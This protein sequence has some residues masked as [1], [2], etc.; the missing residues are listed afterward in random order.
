MVGFENVVLCVCSVEYVT[1]SPDGFRYRSQMFPTVNG[2][3]RWF[4]DHFQEP[5]PG[6]TPSSS[7]RTR[8]PASVNATPANINIADLTRAVSALPR[9]MTS[10]MFSAIAAVT[11]QGQ[12]QNAN[13]TPAQWNSSQYGYTGGSSGGGGGSS[14]AYHVFATPQ[15]PMATPM[16]TP[17]YSYTTPSQ[18]TMG[19]P[20]YPS[21]TP[22]SS[23]GHTQ[24]SHGHQGHS[25]HQGPSSNTPSS[26]SRGRTPQQQPKS[27][28]ST[29][30]DWG[31][32]AEQWLQEK[33]AERKKQKTPR[34][35]P[36][37][38]PSP[39]I[40]STPMSI[41]GDATPLLDEMDR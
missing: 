12:G 16:M 14:S 11:G 19:T 13:T 27:S 41:A 34:M 32:V 25:S 31:K 40:Q 10:Q 17:N 37:P 30:V 35:T 1:I 36:R 33:E 9:N 39:M 7:S 29:A 28:G 4:K 24:S 23:H 8:T 38:S 22:Q 6:I 3:F 26:S 2:L 5:V 20:Q 21:S 15:Q 18:Q